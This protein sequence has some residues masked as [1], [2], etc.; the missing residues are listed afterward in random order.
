M[1]EMEKFYSTNQ[2]GRSNTGRHWKIWQEG[3][4]VLYEGEEDPRY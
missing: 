3:A 2:K 1:K 4:L